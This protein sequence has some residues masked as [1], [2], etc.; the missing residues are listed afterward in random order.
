MTRFAYSFLLLQIAAFWPVWRWY[1]LRMQDGSDEPWGICALLTAVLFL[2]IRGK[3]SRT[4]PLLLVCSGVFV[5]IY[6]VTFHSFP[7]LLRAIISMLALG[8]T[9]SMYLE[10]GS[11]RSLHV[12]LIGLLI[13]SLPIIASLQF[14]LGYPIRLLTTYASTAII[15]FTG[16]P[17]QPDGTCIHWA[18]E[19]VS[20][21]A[22]CSG[23][24]ML[25]TGL[26]LT[27]TLSCLS[28]L[29]AFQTWLSYIVSTLG[30]F[31]GNIIRSTSL[32][33]VESGI[34]DAPS[35]AHQGIGLTVFFLVAVGIIS[36][37]AY[38][39]ERRPCVLR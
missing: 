38:I 21:D 23:I 11:R 22:P 17:A 9:A 31:V 34:L 27:F 19:T 1:L 20:V 32:F 6:A 37:H 25:W 4:N 3:S 29:S 16:F 28:N 2:V 10:S 26:Y 36:F 5:V 33:Y 15:S 7:P 8:C 35:W 39:R 18:G 13:I 14:Y 30:V 12:G 24:R